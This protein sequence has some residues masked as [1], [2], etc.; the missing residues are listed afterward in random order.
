MV[1]FRSLL[2]YEY[3]SIHLESLLLSLSPTLPSR[4]GDLSAIQVATLL[5]GYIVARNCADLNIVRTS[6]GTGEVIIKG[7]ECVYHEN[8]SSG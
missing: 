1:A 5:I 7:N 4:Q 3:E 8:E 2:T 6:K